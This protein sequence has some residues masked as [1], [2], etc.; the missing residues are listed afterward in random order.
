MHLPVNLRLDRVSP[1]GSP[2]FTGS[3]DINQEYLKDNLSNV[4]N[5]IFLIVCILQGLVQLALNLSGLRHFAILIAFVLTR[6]I[7]SLTIVYKVS[8]ESS[9]SGCLP[10]RS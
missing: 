10:M 8:Y 2:Q 5:V 1:K 6:Y 3:V 7:R 4:L 9:L